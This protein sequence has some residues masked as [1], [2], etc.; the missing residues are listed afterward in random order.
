MRSFIHA[1][2]PDEAP[3]APETVAQ[4]VRRLQAEAKA[5]AQDHACALK[6]KLVEL[7]AMAADA[8]GDVY[9]PG[10]RSVARD[11]LLACESSGQTL[12][13]INARNT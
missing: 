10:V 2:E 3:A 11:I 13:A 4:H 9:S 1:V 5:M 6:A 8:G 12:E 7:H